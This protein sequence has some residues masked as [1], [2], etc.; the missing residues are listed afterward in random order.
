MAD[1]HRSYIVGNTENRSPGRRKFSASEL[2]GSSWT[3]ST[4]ADGGPRRLN[5]IISDTTSAGPANSASTLPP[6]RLRTHPSSPH[7]IASCSTQYRK[8]TPCT[9]PRIVT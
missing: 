6:R 8:P 3:A 9:R 2:A 7:A 4:R 1:C 5:A